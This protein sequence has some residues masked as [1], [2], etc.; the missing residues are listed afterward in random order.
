MFRITEN[1]TPFLSKLFIFPNIVC[2]QRRMK[3]LLCIPAYRCIARINEFSINKFLAT[4]VQQYKL[5]NQIR[6]VFNSSI[7]SITT[8]LDW[9]LLK[10]H[11]L[12]FRPFCECFTV[13]IFKFTLYESNKCCC[14][15]FT[16]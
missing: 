1:L 4:I 16:V 13:T 3:P 12:S 5:F 2:T 6:V 11:F 15:L 7:Q 10:S 9:K 8:N 14:P